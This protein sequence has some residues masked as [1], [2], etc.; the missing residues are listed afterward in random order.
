MLSNT[1]MEMMEIYATKRDKVKSKRFK[2]EACEHLL[3]GLDNNKDHILFTKFLSKVGGIHIK[4]GG[5]TN[6]D[7]AYKN[8]EEANKILD[9]IIGSNGYDFIMSVA[10]MGDVCFER[11]SYQE[12][13]A[14]Y[15]RSIKQIEEAYGEKSLLL[16]RIYYSLI[17]LYQ[18]Q[19]GMLL[20]IALDLAMENMTIVVLRYGVES[21]FSLRCILRVFTASA[22]IGASK[23]SQGMLIQMLDTL[24]YTG[25]SENGNKY[26]FEARLSSALMHFSAEDFNGANS[27]FN[28]TMRDLIKYVGDEPDHPF[29]EKTYM[30][31][32]GMYQR[33]FKMDL[34]KYI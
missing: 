32:A 29:L 17:D 26:F 28:E 19:K 23:V 24:E 12:A 20:H 11:K 22:T 3:D 6:L 15:T 7:T 21:V 5:K 25:E 13:E 9:R 10:E 27:I 4:Y 18:A 16:P 34:C 8:Y 33:I 1:M 2:N 31:M 30:H 14:F